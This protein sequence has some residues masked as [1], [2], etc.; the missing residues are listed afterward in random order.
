M[1]IHPLSIGVILLLQ[2]LIITI[3]SGFINRRFWYSYIIFL[4]IVGGIIVLFIYITRVASNEK[5]KFSKSILR[6]WLIILPITLIPVWLNIP[7]V[8]PRWNQESIKIIYYSSNESITKFINQPS[9]FLLFITIIY[10]LVTIIAVVKIANSKKGAL[11][12]KR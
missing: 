6:L 1:L 4:I 5:F 11:R 7:I 8:L 9:N 12:Q 2:T 10:L 3:K